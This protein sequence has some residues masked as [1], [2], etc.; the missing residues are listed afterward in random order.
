[1]P[2]EN[3][4]E[5][6]FFRIGNADNAIDEYMAERAGVLVMGIITLLDSKLLATE[7]KPDP[8]PKLTKARQK[9]GRLPTTIASTVLTLNLAAVRRATRNVPVM[10]HE[11][12]CLHWRRRHRRVLHRG[13]EFETSTVVRRCLVGDPDKGFLHKDYRLTWHMPGLRAE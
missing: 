4:D 1:V 6:I 10:A 8:S 13:S 5:K 7:Q 12:P 9:L 3:E 11:S 2:D